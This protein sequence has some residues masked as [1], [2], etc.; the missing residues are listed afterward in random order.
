M[1]LND[2]VITS[3]VNSLLTMDNDDL[4]KVCELI[5]PFSKGELICDK[6]T[7]AI[8]DRLISQIEVQESVC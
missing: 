3:V 6:L 2:V 8:Q 4:Q 5:A 1:S 7:F